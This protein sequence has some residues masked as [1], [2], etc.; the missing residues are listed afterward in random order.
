M[1]NENPFSG[2]GAALSD[3]VGEDIIRRFG[4]GS[5]RGHGQQAGGLVHHENI[6]V[7]VQ[8]GDALWLM[9]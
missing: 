6:L 5:F 3:V 1:H 8:Y 2:F 7:L 4:I 9:F